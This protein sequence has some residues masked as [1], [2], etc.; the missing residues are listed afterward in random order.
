MTSVLAEGRRRTPDELA[1]ARRDA[2]RMRAQWLMALSEGRATLH[3]LVTAATREGGH[4]LRALRLRMAI[5]HLPGFTRTRTGAVMAELRAATGVDDQV[6]DRDLNVAWLLNRSASHG[7]RLTALSTALL[8]QHGGLEQATV[9]G[10]PY[11]PL[12][13]M[14]VMAR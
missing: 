2:G 8:R 13:G 4:P 14:E 6:P 1:Q 7:A 9:G 3:E 11:G 12:G 10:F 5:E